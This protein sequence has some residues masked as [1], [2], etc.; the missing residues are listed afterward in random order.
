MRSK[1]CA[2]CTRHAKDLDRRAAEYQGKGVQVYIAI[3]EGQ[4]DAA[5]W[6]A[7]HDIVVPVVVAKAGSAHDTVGLTRKVFGSIQQSG[8]IL[9]DSSGV[10]RYAAAATMP[11]GSYDKQGVADAVED[12]SRS[13]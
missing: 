3:P 12:Y 13:R 5:A 1:S 9:V 11:T 10:I 7:K 2:I 4:D 8:T 6:K